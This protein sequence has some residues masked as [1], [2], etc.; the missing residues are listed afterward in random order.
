MHGRLQRTQRSPR[1][2]TVGV[3]VHTRVLPCASGTGSTMAS[4][5]CAEE[6]DIEGMC[7]R[8]EARIN[9]LEKDRTQK[10]ERINALEEEGREKDGQWRSAAAGEYHQSGGRW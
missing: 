1:P 8:L 6:P 9:A 7:K 2:P 5:V 4:T 10:D 3:H